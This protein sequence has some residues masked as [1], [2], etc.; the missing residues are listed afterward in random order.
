MWFDVIQIRYVALHWLHLT[1]SGV[2]TQR[3]FARVQ[4]WV[5]K[6]GA[7]RSLACGIRAA[8]LSQPE[9]EG[10]SAGAPLTVSCWSLEVPAQD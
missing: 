1:A 7:G 2:G 3:R 9:S 5:Y 8:R 6:R 10:Q 4:E